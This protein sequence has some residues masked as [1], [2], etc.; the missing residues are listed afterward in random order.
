VGWRARAVVFARAHLA[1]L[2]LDRRTMNTAPSP[3]LGRE[4]SP[5]GPVV[6]RGVLRKADVWSG[7]LRGEWSIISKESREGVPALLLRRNSAETA[8]RL[9]LTAREIDV[10]Q[11]VANGEPHKAIAAKLRVSIS[12]VATHVR[13]ALKK[14]GLRSR[15]E[16]AWLLKPIFSEVGSPPTASAA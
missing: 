16:V 1:G 13:R 9:A 7:I 15:T 11:L 3:V 6:N 10:L 2:L 14:L 5:S 8:R 4:A 12:T